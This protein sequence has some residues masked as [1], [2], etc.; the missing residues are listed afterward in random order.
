M[1]G[2]AVLP[3][4]AM[5]LAIAICPLWVPHW[6]ERNRNKLLLS[7]AL[8][9]PVAGVYLAQRPAALLH[10]LEEY[11]S[12]MLLLA[13][14]YTIS[15]GI[16]LTGDLEA[17]PLTN[18][19]FLAVGSVLAS[20]IGTTGAS[21]LLIRALLE[22]NRERS[23]VIHTV[24]FFIFLVSNIGGLLTPIGD[25]PL[26]LG[27]LKGVPFFWALRLW[28][29][30]LVAVGALLVTYFVWDSIHHAREPLARLRRDRSELRPL[31]VEG[32]VNALALLGVV[33]AIALLH[34]PWREGLI[35]GLAGVSLWLTPRRVWHANGF[36]AAPM[37]EVAVLFLGIFLTMIPAL[38][39][40]RARGPE[41]SVQAPW[42]FFWATG[43]LSS[44]LDNAPTYLAFLAL[45][46]GL[47]LTNDV[48]GV[49]HE[50]LAAISV[51]AV[52]MGANTYVGNAPNFM[53][54]AMV[55][56]S[57]VKMPTFLGYMGYSAAILLPLFVV[58]TFLLF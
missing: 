47:G 18:T 6:W 25:P 32:A 44:F 51:G 55:E 13:A 42:Q 7:C 12:F 52:F 17:T 49:S 50:V 11:L 20:L 21:V 48:V 14:L 10:T 19:A 22:T 57:G 54:K 15:G 8:G 23:R 41:L 46:Q 3:F 35:L 31:R 56:Q 53:I 29:H 34:A 4:V 26:L 45:A 24:V 28:R 39:I 1:P 16:R 30:W 40:L 9:L 2:Y 27:Y 5:L 38:E 36:T 43:L 33:A 58:L 37:V